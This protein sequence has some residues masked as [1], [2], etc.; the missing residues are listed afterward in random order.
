LLSNDTNEGAFLADND[1]SVWIGVNGG[2]IHLLHHEHL[3]SQNP[4]QIM[5]K[6]AVLG[7]RYL[8]LTSNKD[9]WPWRDAPLD[10]E[11][12]SLDYERQG[13]TR[14]RYRLMGLEPAWNS[15][16]AHRLHYPAM[17]PGNYRFE[18]QALDP[19]QQRQSTIASLDLSIR[20]PWWKT[21]VFYLVL[22]ILSFS[23]CVLIWQW[24]ERRLIKRQQLLKQLIAQRTSELEAEKKEL[25]TAREALHQQAT[26][27]AL[28][29]LWN[30][31]AIL[32]I[33]QREIDQAR[34]EGDPLAVVLA[35][36]DYFKRINDTL[37]H[38]AGD[39]ILRDAAHRMVQKIRPYDF[40][41]RYGGEEFLIVLSGLAEGDPS[42]RLAQLQQAIAQKP[43]LYLVESIQVTC[44]FGV[45]W[46]D[47]DTVNMVDLI[48]RADEALYDAKASGRNCVV[49]YTHP[50]QSDSLHVT[51][52]I[53]ANQAID[54]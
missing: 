2:A 30:R 45:A 32:D 37:G 11:F 10:I 20:P 24:R 35:D 52:E 36:I 49:F 15:T 22:A 5:L 29:D 47:P 7:N 25:L 44:S 21:H 40:I 16:T 17:P 50:S 3:F 4:L 13:S 31:S 43:F 34:R 33:L 26:H 53:E 27:D 46:M 54:D 18:V 9:V 48:R 1:G 19:D 8:K 42:A 28:T 12:T 39:Q 51:V 41:G 14:F 6:S 23:L 38:L